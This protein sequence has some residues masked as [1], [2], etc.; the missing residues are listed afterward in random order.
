M[1]NIFDDVYTICLK[2]TTCMNILSTFG[3]PTNHTYDLPAAYSGV[4]GISA[5]CSLYPE[6]VCKGR[7]LIIPSSVQ[8]VTATI[9]LCELVADTIW[10]IFI[11]F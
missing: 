5:K 7:A 8:Q 10:H 2:T 1:S 3:A 6:A 11:H 9:S 4:A